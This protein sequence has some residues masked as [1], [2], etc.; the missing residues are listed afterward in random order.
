MNL[1]VELIEKRRY[2]HHPY[3]INS[4]KNDIRVCNLLLLKATIVNLHLYLHKL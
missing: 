3:S 1:R 2:H 4:A